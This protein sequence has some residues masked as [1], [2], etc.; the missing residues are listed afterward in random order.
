MNQN[1][2]WHVVLTKPQN[3][4]KV[5]LALTNKGYQCYCPH[6]IVRALWKVQDKPAQKPLFNSYVFVRCTPEQFFDIK[7]TPGVI[8]FM[9]RL[10]QPA[11]VTNEDMAAIKHVI[12]KYSKLQIVN[13][14]IHTPL[15][16]LLQEPDSIAYPIPSLGVTLVAMK[17]DLVTSSALETQES[18]TSFHR[19]SYRFRLAWR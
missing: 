18:K 17:E 19:L 1:V 4:S 7:R 11:V 6:H 9:Y 8:N 3:E 13:S 14:G 15:P 2:C 12:E 10:D 16:T 5:V